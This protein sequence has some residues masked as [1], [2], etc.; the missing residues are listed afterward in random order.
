MIMDE[1]YLRTNDVPWL[2]SFN[3]KLLENDWALINGEKEW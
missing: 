1:V 2:T 3:K